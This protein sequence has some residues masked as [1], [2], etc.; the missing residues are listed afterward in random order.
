MKALKMTVMIGRDRRVV[1]DV[2]DSIREGRAEVVLLTPEDHESGTVTEIG[3]ETHI[4]LLLANSRNRTRTELD[5]EV[6]EQRQSWE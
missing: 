2:P 6:E 4:A 5:R 1:I 3:L